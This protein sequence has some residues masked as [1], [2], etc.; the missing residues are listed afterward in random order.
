MTTNGQRCALFGAMVL[1]LASLG[2]SATFKGRGVD[3]RAD[4][5][6]DER[7]AGGTR[8]GVGDIAPVVVRV[9]GWQQSRRR[10]DSE[11]KS[12]RLLRPWLREPRPFA[13]F[14]DARGLVV[15]FHG[16]ML[17]APRGWSGSL[18][19]AVVIGYGLPHKFVSFPRLED[20]PQ[21]DAAVE[22]DAS[23]VSVTLGD[24]SKP[25]GVFRCGN[26]VVV[27]GLPVAG[28]VA[29]ARQARFALIVTGDEAAIYGEVVALIGHFRPNGGN[30]YRRHEITWTP[31]DPLPLKPT[32]VAVGFGYD[33]GW[34][35]TWTGTF[36]VFR[37]RWA[38]DTCTDLDS[39]GVPNAVHA[40]T[41]PPEVEGIA[42]DD[43][44]H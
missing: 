1:A 12:F 11:V 31:A 28:A 21:S 20:G 19:H 9:T 26:S 44:G 39:V 3:L 25:E 15:E 16:Q 35:E 34:S 27:R 4:V 30:D 2:C 7:E 5:A 22:S 8:F 41:A 13:S 33:G 24:V 17:V 29:D 23:E 40:P 6:I 37:D 10:L 18:A 42:E 32:K 14:A 38:S 36:E 43:D